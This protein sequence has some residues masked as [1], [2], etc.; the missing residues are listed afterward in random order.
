[1]GH[2]ETENRLTMLATDANVRPRDGP[3]T[4]PHLGSRK[5][6]T[7]DG[8]DS[9]EARLAE[10]CKTVS[11]EVRHIV[12]PRKLETLLLGGGYGRGEG[13]VLKTPN[14]DQPYNDLEFY[15]FIYG[16]RFI[17]RRR[18][19]PALNHLAHELTESAGVEVEF[20]IISSDQLRRSNPSMFYYDLVVGH[21]QLCGNTGA[22]RDCEHH[23]DA[24]SLPLAEAIRLLMNRATGLLLAR[25]RI[26]AETLTTDDC[27]FIGR[28]IAKA[29]LALGDAVLT[30]CGQ[31]HWSCRERNRRLAA[32]AP[33]ATQPAWLR[34]VC[35]HHDSGVEFKL[36]PRRTS[37]S[38]AE[39]RKQHESVSDLMLQVWLWV[40]RQR[41]QAEFSSAREYAMSPLD[42][43]PETN[44]ARNQLLNVWLFGPASLMSPSG[45]R[46]PRER[47]LNALSVLLWGEDPSGDLLRQL[48]KSDSNPVDVYLRIWER[49]R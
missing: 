25:E 14:G 12:P 13:G 17:N 15:V 30:V 42:K 40:E 5:R 44:P 20:H 38:V 35:R 19:A 3:S 1:L 21:Q 31:Y 10:I 29:Q 22:L 18:F 36:H 34:M 37:A 28:N 11:R 45:R 48:L 26:S 2:A 24:E 46:H 33:A 6:F 47:V 4:I 43:C 32:L 8:D 41:L 27:D 23:R 7:L 9:L 49:V 39:L 16:N